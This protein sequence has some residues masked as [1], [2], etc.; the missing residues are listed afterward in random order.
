MLQVFHRKRRRAGGMLVRAVLPSCCVAALL[1][2]PLPAASQPL[3]EEAAT[4]ALC[5]NAGRQLA[6]LKS[7]D[8]FAALAPYWPISG[9][10]LQSLAQET[11]AQLQLF[12]GRFGKITGLEWVQSQHRGKSLLRHT[13]LLKF[14]SHAV[15]LECLFYKPREHWL[16]NA[17][18]W[19]DQLE[20]LFD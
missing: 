17:V 5:E 8:A 1:P 18:Y 4:N 14:E 7:G 12:Q 6:Q 16:V 11:Q 20:R 10:E 3:Q 2:L 9:A 15:R 13:Y 19:D